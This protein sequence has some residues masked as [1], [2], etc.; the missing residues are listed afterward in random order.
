MKSAA[1]S[2]QPS[3]VNE[4]AGPGRFRLSFRVASI[5]LIA[6]CALFP[7]AA[8]AKDELSPQARVITLRRDALDH[9]L[10]NGL[11]RDGVRAAALYCEAAKLGDAAS[12][13]D[14]GWMYANGRGVP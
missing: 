8:A 12:Q 3:F 10:G 2:P 13:F 4:R 7:I 6:G 14:L 5:A 9:E 1:S 11:P